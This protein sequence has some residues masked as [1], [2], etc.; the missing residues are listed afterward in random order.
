MPES[1]SINTTTEITS[2]KIAASI[3][4]HARCFHCCDKPVQGK[5]ILAADKHLS[6][7]RTNRELNP[8]CCRTC[9]LETASCSS[10]AGTTTPNLIGSQCG[11]VVEHTNTHTHKHRWTQQTRYARQLQ[12]P[13]QET[14]EADERARFD[15]V[16]LTW[17][18]L[19]A[20]KGGGGVISGGIDGSARSPGKPHNGRF[21][22]HNM[23]P[24]RITA[25]K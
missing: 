18:R 3:R 21:W 10:C 25:Q 24:L 8:K 16:K 9:E 14:P 19:S 13:P 15:K 11:L 5:S 4:R 23:F 6:P 12:Q 2:V 1:L 7:I 22:E 20:P 17:A